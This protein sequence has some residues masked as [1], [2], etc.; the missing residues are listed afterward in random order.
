MVDGRKSN[1]LNV[2]CGT[3]PT[4]TAAM[5]NRDLVKITERA[6]KWKVPFNPEKSKDIIFSNKLLKISHSKT[7]N[8]TCMERVNTCWE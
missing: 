1:V 6:A 3:D 5:I 8:D 4:E 7:F 2:E